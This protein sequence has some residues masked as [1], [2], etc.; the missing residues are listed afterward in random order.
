MSDIVTVREGR[1]PLVL[2]M[3][4]SGVLL[5]ES[6]AEDYRPEAIAL[7]DTDWHIPR[8]YAFAE[9]LDATI[10]A[11]RVSRYVIDLN[12]PPD[13]QSLYPGQAT[14]GLCP[15]TFFDGRPLYRDG[16]EPDEAEIA[17]RVD[18]YWRPYHDAIQ[19]QLDRVW[20]LDHERIVLYDCH[21]IASEVPRLFEGTLPVLNLGTAKGASCSDDISAALTG[22]MDES[23]HSCVT[24]GRFVGGYITRHYGRPADFVEAVQMEIGQDGYM[25]RRPS[26]AYREDLAATLQRTLRSLLETLIAAASG[27]R[28]A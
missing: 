13:G 2:S 22:I 16:R 25:D 27:E 23:P 19:T 6:L 12:R 8:L 9:E 17:R 4:H 20:S 3:P 21:S 18:A 7:V 24:N 1:S 26:F 11:A 14:T 15:T 5:P 10:V 28:G